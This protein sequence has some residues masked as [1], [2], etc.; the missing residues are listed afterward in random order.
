MVLHQS[1]FEIPARFS[2]QPFIAEWVF[3]AAETVEWVN[4][5]T[6]KMAVQA[7]AESE[8][9][10]LMIRI[11]VPE[12]EFSTRRMLALEPVYQTVLMDR[13]SI[14]PEVLRAHENHRNTPDISG[15]SFKV[16]LCRKPEF[17][18]IFWGLEPGKVTKNAWI[19]RD[20]FLNL[21]A[22]RELDWSRAVQQFLNKWGLWSSGTGYEQAWRSQYPMLAKFATV[23]TGE[24]TDTPDFALVMPHLLKAYQER[25]RKALLPSK[26]RNWLS[27]HPL[28]LTTA[29]EFPFFRV[30]KSY[31]SEAIEATI[32]ID[33]LAK[34]RF[35]ICKRCRNVFEKQTGHE[36]NYCSRRCINAASVQR[37]REQQR[38]S[39]KK[40]AKRN[41]KG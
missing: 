33:H 28:N 21:N 40:G 29:G 4:A 22:E 20:E 7:D 9:S 27:L 25:Y 39:A 16:L 24:L 38:K 6:R 11:E 41:A 37:W 35:G 31:C 32:T 12:T 34:K 1:N 8:K 3:A 18:N 2:F 36:K 26:A 19:M 17:R 14:P 30:N 10:W 13:A 5:P 15:R 23:G